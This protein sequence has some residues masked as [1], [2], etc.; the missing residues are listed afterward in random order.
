MEEDKF[1]PLFPLVLNHPVYLGTWYVTPEGAARRKPILRGSGR[2][3]G[4]GPYV[5]QVGPQ[6][7]SRQL[8]REGAV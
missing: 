5:R 4:P 6:L 1:M 3:R 7:L 8:E 2:R